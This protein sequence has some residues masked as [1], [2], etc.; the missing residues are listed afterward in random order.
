[1]T[2][3]ALILFHSRPPGACCH[4][5]AH[6]PTPRDLAKLK[7]QTQGFSAV[8]L[9]LRPL[10]PRVCHT[11]LPTPMS[12][13]GARTDKPLSPKTLPE[14]CP[15]DKLQPPAA[16]PRG[17][18]P[19]LEQPGKCSESL[20][21][22]VCTQVGSPSPSTPSPPPLRASG[23]PFML[24]LEGAADTLAPTRNRPRD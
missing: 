6:S 11:E 10:W 18:E 22:R 16:Q 2:S 24:D 5:P 20:L 12:R 9:L 15:L 17:R 3:S 19:P 8:H 21:E 14:T 23:A 7:C 1:M 13:P 4:S